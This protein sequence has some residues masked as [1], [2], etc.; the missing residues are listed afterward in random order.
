[1][2]AISFVSFS[3]SFYEIWVPNTVLDA[4]GAIVPALLRLPGVT[5]VM[6]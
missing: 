4:V 1:M 5:A 2:I 6:Y 3:H